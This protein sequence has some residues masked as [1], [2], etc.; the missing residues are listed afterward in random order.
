M[1]GDMDKRVAKVRPTA[2]LCHPLA[3]T[4][5]NK[6]RLV[7]AAA[8]QIRTMTIAKD[9]GCSLFHL[10]NYACPDERRDHLRCGRPLIVFRLNWTPSG[11]IA[12]QPR[13]KASPFSGKT[14]EMN[15]AV[16]QRDG[17]AQAHGPLL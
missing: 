11:L 2:A 14:L 12:P 16:R 17:N 9:S 5:E 15:W 4:G 7:E 8:S 3:R 10:D 1:W 6:R 13:S